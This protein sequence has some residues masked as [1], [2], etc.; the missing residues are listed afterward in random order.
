MLPEFELLMPETLEEAVKILAERG[1]ECQIVAGGTDVYV[2][3]HGSFESKPVLLDIKQLEELKVFEYYPGDRLEVGAL[4]THHFLDRSPVVREHFPALAEGASQVGS[5]QIRHRG[6]VGG[7]MC[8]AVPSADTL[9]P[10]LVLDAV[11]VL[12]SSEGSREV[13][14]TEFFLGPKRTV[15]RENELLEKIIIPD[16]PEKKSAYI[17]FTRRNAMDLALLGASASM[18]LGEDGTCKDVRISLTT[19][20]PTPMRARDA[21]AVLEGKKLDEA[22]AEAA[23][24]AASKEAKPRSSWR[25]S[26]EYR[27]EVL[28]VIVP[29]VIMTAADRAAKGQGIPCGGTVAECIMEYTDEMLDQGICPEGK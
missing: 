2:D 18:A 16:A 12:T 20:A 27:R 19:C 5:V 28:K 14:I 26:E 29:R 21:E 13:P 3:M 7:N 22:L 17:K 8:N 1:E 4:I 11:A 24:L 23:G 15:C 6:T 10:L 25:C 9:G